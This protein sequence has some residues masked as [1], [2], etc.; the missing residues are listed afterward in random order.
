MASSISASVTIS[1]I[2]WVRARSGADRNTKVSATIKPVPPITITASRRCWNRNRPANAQ[3]SITSH[4]LQP[5][6]GIGCG[7]GHAGIAGLAMNGAAATI[8][9]TSTSAINMRC[10]LPLASAVVKRW[11]KPNSRSR[12]WWNRCLPTGRLRTAYRSM[13]RRRPKYNAM[14]PTT[15]AALIASGR[16]KPCH[17]DRL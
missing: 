2:N 16:L 14:P 11:A 4:R 13:K 6:S 15:P 12:Q 8:T 10:R 7:A 3:A 9:A 17:T 5:S 1:T